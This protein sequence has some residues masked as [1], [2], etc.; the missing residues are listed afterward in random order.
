MHSPANAPLLLEPYR[1]R[2]RYLL[3]GLRAALASVGVDKPPPVDPSKA[4][5]GLR[6]LAPFVAL[7]LLGPVVGWLAP[8]LVQALRTV[9]S[10]RLGLAVMGALAVATLLLPFYAVLRLWQGAQRLCYKGWELA[11]LEVGASA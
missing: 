11:Q 1:C 10:P 7:L 3:R 2:P 6:L 9:G 5:I 8:G 4:P